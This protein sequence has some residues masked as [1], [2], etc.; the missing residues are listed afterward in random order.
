MFSVRVPSVVLG[1]QLSGLKFRL[2]GLAFQ[3]FFRSSNCSPSKNPTVVLEFQV[4]V[5]WNSNCLVW[6]S[7]CSFVVPSVPRQGSNCCLGIPTVRSGIPT[8]GSGIPTVLQE[9]QVC[10]GIIT[11]VA[12]E[13]QLSGLEFQRV[14]SGIPTVLSEFPLFPVGITTVA[15][16]F[17]L[18][19]SGIPTVRSEIPTVP[20]EIQFLPVRATTVALEF[21]LS[22][23][24]FQLSGLK[25]QLFFRSSKRSPSELQLLSWN[26][27][28]PVWNSKCFC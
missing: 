24:E 20:S 1:F 17:Q 27:K 6:D 9:F 18:S 23:L 15:L 4:F 19:R 21:Q 3:S 16:E 7:N 5:I 10:S 8:V 25:F 14:G 13:F 12:L 22:G 28:C 11:I 2:S 26:S